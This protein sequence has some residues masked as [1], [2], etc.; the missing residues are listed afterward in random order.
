MSKR[1]TNRLRILSLIVIIYMLTALGWWSYL[2]Y[3]KNN[4][5]FMAKTELLKITLAAKGEAIDIETF[6]IHPEFV[7]LS[8]NYTSQER[9]IISEAI[10]LAIS[11]MIGI[12]F[13]NQGY[14][15]QTEVARQSRNFLLSIT[16]ELKSPL[17]SIRL[18]LQTF[19]KRDLPKDKINQ[20][21]EA[22]LVETDRLNTLV[23][24]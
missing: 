15:K 21:S 4:D 16:H 19:V 12:W 2:L 7:S 23:N 5:A 17:A 10:V 1:K 3:V 14:S 22:A 13:I 9:M 24:N 8:E 11:L 20:F 6:R 18:I